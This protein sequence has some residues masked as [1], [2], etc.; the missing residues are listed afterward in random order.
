MEPDFSSIKEKVLSYWPDSDFLFVRYREGLALGFKGVDAYFLSC[1]GLPDWVAPNIMFCFPQKNDGCYL[2]V[3]EDRDDRLIMYDKESSRIFVRAE[4]GREVL[5]CF[6]FVQ[7]FDILFFYA[8]MVDGAVAFNRL[9]Y[10][11]NSIPDDLICVFE[12]SIKGLF[13]D[14]EWGDCFWSEEISR[15]RQHL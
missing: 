14:G 1:C 8:D 12:Y 9:A 11:E 10:S 7:F 5:L 2:V 6:G 15:L 4:N 13:S 3:G